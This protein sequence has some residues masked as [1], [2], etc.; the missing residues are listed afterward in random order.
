[1][2]PDYSTENLNRLIETMSEW[3]M[4]RPWTKEQTAAWRLRWFGRTPE[5]DA[6]ARERHQDELYD[7]RSRG[8]DRYEREEREPFNDWP[9]GQLD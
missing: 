3:S 4:K 1:M 5:Q 2:E 9:S 6:E 8:F 7:E